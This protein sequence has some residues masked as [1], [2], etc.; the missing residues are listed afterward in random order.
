MRKKWL[1]SLVL[2]LIIALWGIQA[3]AI[4]TN[5]LETNAKNEN[6]ENPSNVQELESAEYIINDSDKII[7]RVIPETQIDNFINNFSI[8]SQIKVYSN[9]ECTEEV[10]TGIIGTGMYLKN[11]TNNNIYEISTIGDFDGDG[12]IGQIELTNLIRHVVGLRDYQLTGTMFRSGDLNNDN[13]LNIVDITILI[14]YIVFGELDIPENQKVA[15]P[16]IEV[17]SGESGTNDWYTSKVEVKITPNEDSEIVD[18]VTYK[19]SGTKQIDETEITSNEKITLE[20]GTYQI[21]AYTYA[22]SGFKS[23]ASRKT[24]KID[25]TAPQVGT[26]KMW[27]DEEN[28]A[29]YTE[30]TWTAHDIVLGVENGEDGES[31][32]YTTTYTVNGANKTNQITKLTSSNTYNIIV[33]TI[34]NAGNKSTSKNYIVKIDKEAS[35]APIIKVIS[36]D[37]REES[38]WYYSDSVV[39]Q[40]TNENI[41]EDVP[42]IVKTTYTIDGTTQVEE[43]ELDSTGK[44]T[45]SE[46]GTYTVTVY[47]YNEAGQRS[48]GATITIKKDNTTPEAPKLE[49]ISGTQAENTE[50]YI[51]DVTVKIMQAE[52]AEELSKISKIV[53]KIE[54]TENVPETEIEN[55]GTIQ[56]TKDGTYTITAYNYNEAG[57]CSRGTTLFIQ[58]DSTAPNVSNISAK[59]VTGGSFTLVGEGSDETSGII[60]YEFYVNEELINKVNTNVKQVEVEV[61]G[62]EAGIYK[63]YVIVKDA[64]GHIKKSTEISIQ[65]NKISLDEIDYFEFVI[66]GFTITRE[67]ENVQDGV[68]ATISDTSLTSNSKYIMVNSSKQNTKGT[69]TGKLR[70]VNKNGTITEDFNYFPDELNINMSYYAN[71]SGTRFTH[72]NEVNFLGIDL[73]SKNVQDGES[74]ETNIVI[75]DENVKENTFTIID[76]KLTGTQTYTRATINSVTLNGEKIPFRIVQE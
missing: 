27:I 2:F 38:D 54:G 11:L 19:I 8:P 15:P 18:K 37:K 9:S 75:S 66:T 41:S 58:K 62:K 47:N 55:E 23:L 71:G 53:Y 64:A 5:V 16:N 36:G 46:N 29:E 59:D 72:N 24:I 6:A 73:N 57:A 51:D 67:D 12:K 68:I 45:I 30:N 13:R 61:T 25:T 4:N 42:Q 63:A 74:V 33:E 34:D 7:Y 28:G 26:L 35:P 32:H 60:T 40:V 17:I 49:V 3:K 43:T 50:W 76:E 52:V 39:L 56:I 22:K 70:L 65:T 31:G 1:F 44:I 14:R 21:S 69:V 10:T 48:E 20:E